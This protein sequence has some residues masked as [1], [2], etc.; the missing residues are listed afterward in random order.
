ME[1]QIETLGGGIDR[2]LVWKDRQKHYVEAQIETLYEETD[3]NTS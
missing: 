2:N 3:S 1:A